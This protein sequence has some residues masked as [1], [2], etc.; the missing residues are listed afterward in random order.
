MDEKQK[1]DN[2]HPPSDY[3]WMKEGKQNRMNLLFL[4][5]QQTLGGTMPGTAQTIDFGKVKAFQ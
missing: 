3:R 5:L 2:F 1:D 4:P